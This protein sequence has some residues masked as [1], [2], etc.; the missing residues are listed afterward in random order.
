MRHHRRHR[1]NQVSGTSRHGAETRTSI[2]ESN[3][4]PIL[5]TAKGVQITVYGNATINLGLGNTVLPMEVIVA[6]IVDEFI[7]E[8]DI[9]KQFNFISVDFEKRLL[10]VGNE[11][12]IFSTSTEKNNRIRLIMNEDVRIP[13]NT[14]A[15]VTAHLEGKPDG[16]DIFLVEPDASRHE[17]PWVTLKKGKAIGICEPVTKVTKLNPGQKS[18]DHTTLPD[19][20]QSFKKTWDNLSEEEWKKASRFVEEE[21]DI[22]AGA[23]ITG[24]TSLVKHE[25]DTGHSKPIRQPP[26]RLPFAKQ[27]EVVPMINEMLNDGV[28][29]ES[30]ASFI[31]R[32]SERRVSGDRRHGVYTKVTS[33]ES[34]HVRSV[35]DK[36]GNDDP[37]MTP[38]KD[39]LREEQGCDK[40]LR[41]VR[42]WLGSGVRPKWQ[43]ISRHGPT[44]K[45]YWLQWDSLCLRDDLITRIWE[46]PD[47][48]ATVYQTIVPSV[49]CR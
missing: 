43:E 41:I 31:L 42:Q 7:L 6:D 8:L 39:R 13:G 16:V 36:T 46:S 44:V 29:E 4:R 24:R 22:F 28:I 33:P 37:E 3:L 47:G 12:I 45:G 26:R 34:V 18:A 20:L 40:D 48:K 32:R 49:L 17:T 15:I 38:T 9:M 25:I 30:K 21:A 19:V 35:T 23:K 1:C 14:E 10:K 2:N 11:E 27:H 5:K